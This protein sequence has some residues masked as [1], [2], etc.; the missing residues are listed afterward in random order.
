MLKPIL[1]L[2]YVFVLLKLKQLIFAFEIIYVYWNARK[3]LIK[4]VN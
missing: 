3:S 1:I 2:S 4:V